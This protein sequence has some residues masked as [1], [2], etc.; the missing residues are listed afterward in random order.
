LVL[1]ITAC[2]PLIQPFAPASKPPDNPLLQLENSAGIIVS[3]IAGM[4]KA[5]S[6]R[7]T[8]LL[9]KALR[10]RNI[11][12]STGDSR[13][14]KTLFLR[15][16]IGEEAEAGAPAL[17]LIEWKL[18]SGDGE[19][20]GKHRESLSKADWQAADSRLFERLTAGAAKKIAGLLR[21]RQKALPLQPLAP[22]LYVW[23]IDKAPGDGKQSLKQAI[24]EALPRVFVPL[25]RTLSDASYVL[26]GNVRLEDERDT[27]G[28]I[29][30][31]RVA[32]TWTVIGPDGT[33]IGKVEQNNLVPAGR[34]NRPWGEIARQIARDAAQG[35][36]D[37]LF[38]VNRSNPGDKPNPEATR[39]LQPPHALQP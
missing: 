36:A 12:A 3:P 39:A 31:M 10:Q 5:K 22:A 37:L 33:E 26:L 7:L 23:P 13:N 34:L 1:L 15:G 38:T 16:R 24:E 18:L 4:S 32:V 20:L 8:A 17:M 28:Q 9:A 19:T 2:Q 35:I 14:H 30:V 21:N 6:R 11:P 27:P 29:T 25:A